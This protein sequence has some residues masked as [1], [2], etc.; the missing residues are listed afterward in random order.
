MQFGIFFLNYLSLTWELLFNFFLVNVG[1]FFII[2]ATAVTNLE[3]CVK[4]GGLLKVAC[5]KDEKEV[6]G[7]CHGSGYCCCG[8]DD[9]EWW[10]MRKKVSIHVNLKS[11]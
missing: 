1:T 11:W 5:S 9:S 3:K 6:A 2:F 4:A 10:R 8:P 7:G